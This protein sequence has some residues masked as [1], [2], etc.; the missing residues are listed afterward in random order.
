MAMNNLHLYSL[1]D[2]CFNV[3]TIFCT[4]ICCPLAR[5]AEYLGWSI[6]VPLTSKCARSDDQKHPSRGGN[7][8]NSILTSWLLL[9]NRSGTAPFSGDC[10]IAYLP[11]G[12]CPFVLVS[13]KT[14]VQNGQSNICRK[15]LFVNKKPTCDFFPKPKQFWKGVFIEH[16]RGQP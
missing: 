3:Q 2:R 13:T 10:R 7:R 16:V 15:P 14:H 6:L 11:W 5:L 12:F 9:V 4:R 1:A 8:S